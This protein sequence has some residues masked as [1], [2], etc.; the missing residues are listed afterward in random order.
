MQ[1]SWYVSR[2]KSE[3]LIAKKSFP[4]HGAKEVVT[5]MIP[6]PAW[7]AES[8]IFFG[9]LKMQNHHMQLVSVHEQHFIT[10]FVRK[11]VLN[12]QSPHVHMSSQIYNAAV[13]QNT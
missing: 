6:Y 1:L 11:L 3:R 5:A 7:T 12:L 9:I 10:Y 8:N 2:A 13:S 4:G